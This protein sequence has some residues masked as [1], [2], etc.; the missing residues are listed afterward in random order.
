V[1]D[2]PYGFA[3]VLELIAAFVL[4][5][6][7]GWE[8]ERHDRSMGI[9]TFPLIG[10]ASCAFVVVAQQISPDDPGAWNR[11]LEGVATGVGFLGA[12]A[13]VKHGIA[14]LGTATAAGVWL[15][16]AMG[17]SVGFGRWGVAV[18]L[19]VIGF[20]TLRIFRRVTPPDQATDRGDVMQGDVRPDGTKR[21]V[22][23]GSDTVRA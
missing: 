4:A 10:V 9:R 23:E 21:P 3:G 22:A 8:R 11:T 19:S 12:G 6:P 2:V 14:V 1:L 15:T 16:A 18:A 20:A 5:L 17:A 7:V 13:I